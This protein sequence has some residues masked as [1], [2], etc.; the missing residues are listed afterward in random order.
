MKRL[1]ITGSNGFIGSFLVEE[2]LKRGYEV[3]ACI[4]KSSNVQYLIDKRIIFLT[5]DFSN[6]SLLIEQFQEL[7]CFDFVIHNAGLT[8]AKKTE[9]YYIVNYKF[10]KNLVNALIRSGKIPERFI[11]MSSL[12]AYGPGNGNSQEPVKLNDLPC[13]ISSYGSS[14]LASE[15][16]ISCLSNFP[17]IILRPTAVYGPREKDIYTL[18]KLI[19]RNIEPFIGVKNQQL[20]FIYVKDLVK[21]V[22]QCLESSRN[23]KAYFVTDGQVYKGEEFTQVIKT[24]L[25]KNTIRIFLPKRIIKLFA[26]FLESIY[27]IVGKTPS[28]NLEKIK[29]IESLNWTC[30]IMPLQHDMNFKADYNLHK[31]IDETIEWYKKERWI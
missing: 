14:K 27:W 18:F 11:Y 9:D 20:T 10:T 28:L 8:K 17:Y 30:D 22:F 5:I 16:Y 15:K 25:Q 24:I 1:L 7:P 29:E 6:P 3:Y 13:P 4:R 19:N 23:N 21:V 26:Y 31:G 2:A 12:A